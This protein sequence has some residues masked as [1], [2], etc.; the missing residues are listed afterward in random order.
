M[1]IVF[2]TTFS[3]ISY[4]YSYLCRSNK[5]NQQVTNFITTPSQEMNEIFKLPTKHD[6]LQY[7]T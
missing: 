2:L 7:V 5:M 6:L 3:V 1:D 4:Y